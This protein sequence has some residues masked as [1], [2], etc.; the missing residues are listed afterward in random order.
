MLPEPQPRPLQNRAPRYEVHI[1]LEF[2]ADGKIV[3]G[4]CIN[5]SESGVL[6]WFEQP[7]E[8]WISGELRLHSGRHSCKVRARV[9]RVIERE[10]GLSFRL[11]DDL[12]ERSLSFIRALLEEVRNS[13]ATFT[14]PY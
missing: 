3:R 4:R 1:P 13:G 6:A 9:S 10:A 5:L 8:L 11:G 14:P 2:L 7:L 12:T